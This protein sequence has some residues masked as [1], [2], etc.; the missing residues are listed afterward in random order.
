[1]NMVIDETVIEMGISSVR[2]EFLGSDLKC[3]KL[4]ENRINGNPLEEPG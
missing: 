3:M 1:M 4:T 2:K